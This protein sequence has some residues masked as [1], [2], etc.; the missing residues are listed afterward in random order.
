MQ[1]ELDYLAR[2]ARP[3]I[4]HNTEIVS[5]FSGNKG[6]WLSLVKDRLFVTRQRN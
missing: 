3:R 1:L 4:R 5:A 6:G 2:G